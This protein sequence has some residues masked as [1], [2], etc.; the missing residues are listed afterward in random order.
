MSRISYPPM[1]SGPGVIADT[2]IREIALAAPPPVAT[3]LLASETDPGRVVATA[4]SSNGQESAGDSH[5]GALCHLPRAGACRG[6]PRCLPYTLGSSSA[7]A[8]S[9]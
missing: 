4:A 2:I 5:T 6:G 7:G 8:S 1:P 9:P 3:F